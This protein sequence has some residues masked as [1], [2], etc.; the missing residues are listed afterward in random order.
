[1]EKYFRYLFHTGADPF[2][3]LQPA[4]LLTTWG[5]R[6]TQSVLWPGCV[7]NAAACGYISS[8][9]CASTTWGY[10]WPQQHPE[11]WRGG[12]DGGGQMPLSFLDNFTIHSTPPQ[13]LTLVLTHSRDHPT[14]KLL[15]I[16]CCCSA[17]C[18]LLWQ[19]WLL[20]VFW[21]Y[22]KRSESFHLTQW[23][24][25]IWD[26]WQVLLSVYCL[27]CTH[28]WQKH[29][30]KWITVKLLVRVCLTSAQIILFMHV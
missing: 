12:T 1:M 23:G 27:L 24:Q 21:G 2:M 17:V 20:S 10:S 19:L 22:T 3:H 26:V 8:P 7:P 14:K 4:S 9:A 13:N 11:G 29:D 15:T 25:D 16:T 18:P 5:V 28:N 30:S 6:S